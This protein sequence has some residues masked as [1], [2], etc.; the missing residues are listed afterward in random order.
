MQ[1]NLF[2][3]TKMMSINNSHVIRNVTL[4]TVKLMK[5]KSE[6]QFASGTGSFPVQTALRT[7]RG[8]GTQPHYESLS[9]RRVNNR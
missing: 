8:L 3:Q 1:I 4:A 2:L 7:W 9:E 5:D 6:K